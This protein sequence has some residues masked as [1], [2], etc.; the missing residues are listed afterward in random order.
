[1][2]IIEQLER[3]LHSINPAL[4]DG[5]ELAMVSSKLLE[6]N[7]PD[8]IHYHYELL[9]RHDNH[10]LLLK[11]VIRSAFCEREAA[12]EQFLL[13]MIVQEKDPEMVA[14][15]LQ[16]LGHMG[17]KDALNYALEGLH[18][19]HVRL[20]HVA[21]IVLGWSGTIK[22]LDALEQRLLED[23]VKEIREDAATAYY[24]M[25]YRIPKIKERAV[26]S[27]KRGLLQEKDKDVLACILV[28]LQDILSQRF[29]MRENIEEAEITGNVERGKEKA[30]KF[31]EKKM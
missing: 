16:I 22:H 25:F 14:E 23:P 4:A 18:S 10:S 9:R 28:T 30:L 12:G 15:I 2:N 29:G 8:V 3:Q 7:D 21:T 1:M 6:S 20:R 27:L 13:Q 11:G 26:E 24:Q 17:S 31:L 5:E 19:K